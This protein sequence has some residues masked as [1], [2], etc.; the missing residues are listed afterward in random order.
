MLLKGK[1]IARE[2]YKDL[3]T[4]V[5]TLKEN[6]VHPKLAVVLVGDDKPSE[7]YVKKKGDAA[8]R[9]GIAFKL[10]R[11]PSDIKKDELIGGINHIQS[12][13]TV[14]GLIVQLPLPNK[15]WTREILNTIKPEVDVDCL[16]DEN[17]GK[18]VAKTSIITPPT[19]A[20]IISLLDSINVDYVGKNVTVVGAGT[21]VGKPL[22]I[23]LMN[24]RASVTTC[25]IK[26]TDT[27]DKCKQADI[28]VSGVGK[29]HLIQADMVAPGAIVIDAGVS[30]IDG[31]MSGDVDVE[32]VEQIASYVTPTPGGVGPLTVAHLL[33][34][35]VILAEQR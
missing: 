16:T 17:F 27:E 13:E 10:H 2:I 34:N 12:D 14:S 31:E 33:R 5:A 3:K 23:M 28:I 25:N 9:V 15:E 18:L 29:A 35:T 32:K 7:T 22:A 21:L 26:T 20:A 6:G 11:F 1:P 8:E 4:R 19:P 30:F 24:K